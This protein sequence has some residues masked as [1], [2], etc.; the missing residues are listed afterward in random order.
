MTERMMASRKHTT[1]SAPDPARP[2]E[3]AKPS[4]LNEALRSGGQPL[5]AGTRAV[6]E[7][8]FGHDF[9]QVRVHT[10]ERAATSADAMN[11]LAYTVGSDI[12]FAT[13]QYATDT[14]AGQQLIAHELAHTLQQPEDQS[15]DARSWGSL[16]VADA[17]SAD[18]R[19]A[20]IAANDA[21]S[22]GPLATAP[23]AARADHVSIQR[24]A[25][26][27]KTAET[28]SADT[29]SRTLRAAADVLQFGLTRLIAGAGPEYHDALDDLYVAKLGE[30]NG[31][32]VSGSD[33]LQLLDNALKRLR[34]AL[35]AFEKDPE[36][37]AW[38][39]QEVTPYAD[40]LRESLNS[41]KAQERLARTAL[42]PD[43]RLVEIP[44]DADPHAIGALLHE[45]IPRL[46][47]SIKTIVDNY[48]VSQ[49]QLARAGE[50][51][52]TQAGPEPSSGGLAPKPVQSGGA[53]EPGPAG[54]EPSV[55]LLPK[56]RSPF[57]DDQNL[58]LDPQNLLRM[59]DGYLILTDDEFAEDLSH[60]NEYGFFHGVATYAEFVRAVVQLLGGMI[61]V[62]ASAAAG[63]AQAQGEVELAKDAFE[64]AEGAT[65]VVGNIV[66][67]IE[68]V[69]GI[70]VLLD[71]RSTG[72]QKEVAVRDIAAG[73][74]W[75][76]G[77]LLSGSMAAGSAASSAVL[78]LYYEYRLVQEYGV[79]REGIVG[80]WM[81]EAF[82]SLNESGQQIGRNAGE[83]AKAGLL[84]AGERQTDQKRALASIVTSSALGLGVAVDD[85]LE[86]CLP[87]GYG[88]GA[89]YKP[90]AYV[91]LRSQF[92][93]LLSLKGANTP[94]KAAS[95]AIA[96][97]DKISWCF[98]HAKELL[99]E[100]LGGAPDGEQLKE[101]H[102]TSQ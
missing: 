49:E 27:S 48:R 64:L 6:M 5:D 21:L 44:A 89:A 40:Q 96:V 11:A 71:K 63:L 12:V 10:D 9:S 26:P 101:K 25:A 93:P 7:S 60:V 95:A 18:E 68:I 16:T 46:Q 99:A 24:R 62:T 76:G 67:G 69:H 80:T 75:F 102:R 86:D 81:N 66:A 56:G 52:T 79:A 22:R 100:E 20:D 65:G 77:W 82:E 61:G 84:L 73:S 55:Q 50:A 1:E 53:V 37:K 34:P 47:E 70:A 14:G 42:T 3:H 72:E 35:A 32:Q 8:R 30:K 36:N 38:L 4:Q 39:A 23:I 91:S 58:M 78:M 15:A 90:G 85:F 43:K 33:R 98:K 97:L 51:A 59:I 57:E 19:A 94:D 28:D 87:V 31:K 13:G 83:L 41:A 29:E 54:N 88:P 2:R 74:A 45:E 17:S 92:A